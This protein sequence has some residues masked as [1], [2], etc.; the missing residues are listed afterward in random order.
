MEGDLLHH[1]L[2]ALGT[3][4][5]GVSIAVAFRQSTVLGYL[6]AG[7]LVGPFTPGFVAPMPTITQLAELGV[8]FLMFAIGVQLP[9]RELISES[10][11]ATIGAIIQVVGMIGIGYGIGLLFG[12]GQVEAFAFGC[13]LSNSSSAVISKVLGDRDEIDTRHA[14]TSIAWS[15]VQDISTVIL[16]AIFTGMA[17]GEE[18]DGGAFL[19]DLGSAAIFLFVLVPLAFLILPRL[20]R[21]VASLKSRELFVL[22][23]VTVAIAMA[24]AANAL[25]ASVALGAFLA[26]AI[27][28]ESDVSHR[29]LGD[30]L[31]LRDIFSGVFFVS[32]GMLLDPSFVIAHW[33]IV[34]G[35]TFAI[36]VIKGAL[37]TGIYLGLGGSPRQAVLVGACLAQSAEFSFLLAHHGAELGVVSPKGFSL[38]LSGAALSILVAPWVH[39][40]V[41]YGLTKW[42]IR[43]EPDRVA[44]E[45]ADHV[46]VCG[47]G[48]VG[49]VVC[50]VLRRVG[51]KYVV[52]E[53]DPHLVEDLRAA[54]VPAIMG[55]AAHEHVLER[56]MLHDAAALVVCVPERQVVRRIVA[57]ARA[58]KPELAIFV[59]AHRDDERAHL[60]RLYGVD[61]VFG[62]QELSLE[63]SRRTATALG[64][65][66]DALQRALTEARGADLV[67]PEGEASAS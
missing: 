19:Q 29:V 17:G 28:G 33:P 63:L 48:R 30:A 23:V 24:S 60:E 45:L 49:H 65:D 3:A 54:G 2:L 1:L 5:A 26:G 39:Q 43:G 21:R 57:Y 38:M 9:L 14:N 10:R 64:V 56:A 22:V 44:S 27:V 50:D 51:V 52:I 4:L 62:E 37:S 67:L 58:E 42:K 34:L 36:V 11:T 40:A 61:A 41:G 7:L 13:V 18:D 8:V 15:S 12:F 46:V 32:I 47:Y 31:P 59:R 20:L 16:V 35:T 55:D 66:G 25:G 6:L 53:D